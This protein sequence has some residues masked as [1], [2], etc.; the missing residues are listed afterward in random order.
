MREGEVPPLGRERVGSSGKPVA[1][2]E[3]PREDTEED[4]ELSLEDPDVVEEGTVGPETDGTTTDETEPGATE[5]GA[6]E[7]DTTGPEPGPEE[8]T[9]E[10]ER[11]TTGPE[12]SIS[13]AETSRGTGM[14]VLATADTVGEGKHSGGAEKGRGS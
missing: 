2:G 5:P 1:E 4:T 8:T 12:S 14:D 13:M 6:T 11:D 9:P 10:P 3:E 7:P